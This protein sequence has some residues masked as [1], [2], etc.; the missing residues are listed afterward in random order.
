MEGFIFSAWVGPDFTMEG[1]KRAL[2]GTMR[3]VPG[4]STPRRVIWGEVSKS[5]SFVESRGECPPE[6]CKELLKKEREGIADAVRKKCFSE[7]SS[8]WEYQ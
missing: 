6:L 1:P 5:G 3:V 7:A 4:D 8:L 2:I